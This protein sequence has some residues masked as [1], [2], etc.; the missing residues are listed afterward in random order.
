MNKPLYQSITEYRTPSPRFEVIKVKDRVKTPDDY[1][2]EH[3]RAL[4]RLIA[5]K[6]L[7]IV[8]DIAA[9]IALK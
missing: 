3:E 6:H 5:R 8:L 9:E 4:L 1:Q 7:D 2:R